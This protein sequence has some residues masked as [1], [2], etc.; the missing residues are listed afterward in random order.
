M[1]NHYIDSEEAAALVTDEEA[2]VRP[3]QKIV[4]DEGIIRF[5][6]NA[7][8]RMLLDEGPFDLNQ[9]AM[10]NFSQ[11]DREQFTQLIGYSVSGAG[12]LSCM[13]P[14]TIQRADIEAEKLPEAASESDEPAQ[15]ECY[16]CWKRPPKK[17]PCLA[18]GVGPEEK[19]K[20]EEAE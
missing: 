16:Y 20:D 18:C 17:G 10:R 13:S 15:G 1:S 12:D 8:V 7:I 2:A 4:W 3:M 6:R 11:E 9:I 19:E 14:A 5:R